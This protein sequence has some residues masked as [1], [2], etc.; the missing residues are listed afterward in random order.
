[1]WINVLKWIGYKA[2]FY[3]W[4]NAQ[5]TF[6]LHFITQQFIQ[7]LKKSFPPFPKKAEKVAINSKAAGLHSAAILEKQTYTPKF[8]HDS[9]NL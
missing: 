7:A 5:N 3:A 1:M 6:S 4:N 9:C 8:F 2:S